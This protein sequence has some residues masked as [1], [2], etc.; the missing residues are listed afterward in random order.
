MPYISQK[1]SLVITQK[2]SKEL[3]NYVREILKKH[4]IKF[5]SGTASKVKYLDV[6]PEASIQAD[7][8][9]PTCENPET[10][11]DITHTNPDKAG[12]SNE[13]KLNQ[14]IG[15]LYLWKAYNPNLRVI[16]VL[17]GTENSWLKYVPK[18]FNFFFDSCVLLWEKDFETKLISSLSCELK[19]FELWVQENK[20]VSNI[21]F[22]TDESKAQI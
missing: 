5:D 16:I 12:H 10:I 2:K 4:K 1:K 17:G 20:R 22:L 18:A 9:I 15:E 14:K 11:I 8:A 7:I 3:D 19:N 13:N 6:N 21:K